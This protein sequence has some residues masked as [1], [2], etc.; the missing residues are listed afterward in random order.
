M[1]DVRDM[2]ETIAFYERLGF[3][4]AGTFGVDP[5][6]PTWCQVKRGNVALMFTWSEPHAHD[7]DDGEMHSHDPALAGLLYINTDD[8]DALW[9]ELRHRVDDVVY[10]PETFP[11]RMRE[12]A[13]RDPNGY[14]LVFGAPVA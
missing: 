9:D 3:E 11:H 13:V 4:L 8:V 14:V 5:A 12:F 2:R 7:D 1:L 6:K 10:A